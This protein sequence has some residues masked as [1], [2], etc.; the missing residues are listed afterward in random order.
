MKTNSI[1]GMK[2]VFIRSKTFIIS[3][4]EDYEINQVKTCLPAIDRLAFYKYMQKR[5][6]DAELIELE[7][8]Y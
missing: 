3:N 2:I 6:I 4:I 7:Y 5:H 1:F 8:Q